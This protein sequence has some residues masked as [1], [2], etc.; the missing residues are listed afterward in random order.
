MYDEEGWSTITAKTQKKTFK[1][2]IIYFILFHFI[3]MESTGQPPI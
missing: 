2:L 1:F 3:T